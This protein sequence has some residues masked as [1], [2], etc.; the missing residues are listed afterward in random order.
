VPVSRPVEREVTDYVEFTGQTRAVTPVDIRP[1]VTGYLVKMPFDEGSEVKAGDLLF[2]I[3]PRPYKATLDQAQGQVNLYLAQLRLAKTTLAR[4][5]AV[6]ASSPGSVSPQQFD[7]EQAVVDEAQA[8]VELSEKS[9]ETYRLNYEFTKVVSP[10]DGQVSRYYLTLGNLV[11]ADQS[12]LTTVMSVDPMYAYFQVDKPTQ[13]RFWRAVNEGKIKA[14]EDRTKIPVYM[15]LQGEEDFP[16]KGTINFE[17]NQFNPGTGTILV[18]GVFPNPLPKGGQRLLSPGM[19]VRIRLP[20]GRP[21]QAVLIPD[22]AIASDQGIKYVY[23]IDAENK[24]QYRRVTTGVLDGNLRVIEEGLKPDERILTG[25]LLRVRPRMLIKP[26]PMPVTPSGPTNQPAPSPPERK[27]PRAEP[28]IVPVSRPVQREVTDYVDYTGETKAVHSVDI[29]PRVTG[30]LVKM[31]FEEGAEVKVG[32]LL[33]VVDPRPY[34]AQLDEARGQVN[35]YQAQLK[36][37][38]TTLARDRAVNALAPGSVSPQQFDQ[39]QAV[40]DEAQ[41]RVELYEKSMENYRLNHEFTHVTSP[42]DGQ[43]SSYYFHLGNLVNQDQTHLTT[44][45]SV[46]PMYAYFEMDEP[47]VLRYRKA[48]NEGR[49]QMP[50]D[51]RKVPVY[52]GVQGEDGFPHAGTI[53]FV[54]NQVNPTKGTILVRG[55]F[56]N[57][58]RSGGRRALSPGMFAKIRLPVGM[59]HQALLVID[60]AVGSDQGVKYVYVLDDDDKVRT[61]RVTTGA[62]EDDGLRVIDEGLKPDDWVIS[63]GLLQVQARMLIKPVRVPMPT[64]GTATGAERAPAES[65]ST[66][67]PAL[68]KA[69]GQEGARP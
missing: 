14:P 59:P 29:R 58:T 69:K 19:F 50:A 2:V 46:D 15:S 9:M 52:M 63:G 13:E 6:N 56:P 33:F 1:R 65:K 51:R 38:R 42:I 48:I 62:L 49:I 26:D 67:G 18:R 36:L 8:R 21:H 35:L 61:Q 22:Q 20:I 25:G 17:N 28:P 41:A 43:I 37:A 31:P 10:I 64:I 30:Y 68:E 45:V 5:K 39:E 23:V 7:Q 57:P 60:R 53:N 40:V 11:N 24:A 54:N 34:K 47:T 12:L 44:V 27:G 16:H 55:V 66:A 32:N 3:D 4:D